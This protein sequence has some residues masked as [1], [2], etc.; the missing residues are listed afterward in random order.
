[1]DNDLIRNVE[2]DRFAAFIGIRLVSVE[3]GHA[4]VEMK[5]TENH[6]NGV[7]FVQG[8]AI[9]TLADYAFA[10]ASNS[11]GLLTTGINASITYFKTPKGKVLTAEATEVSTQ[12]RTCGYSVNVYDENK[13]LIAQFSG[14]GYIKR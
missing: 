7:G 12:N 4:V 11:K 5:L 9:F 14:L 2:N 13:D 3:A 8:G 10:A 1:M 6:L